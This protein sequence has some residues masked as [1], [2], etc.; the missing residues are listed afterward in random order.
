MTGDW[1]YLPPQYRVTIPV[2]QYAATLATWL[3]GGEGFWLGVMV[4]ICAMQTCY[5]LD[6]PLKRA[7]STF[8]AW[9]T[10]P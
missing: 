3:L 5:M 9:A 4:G 6:Q 1:V 8:W 10:R 7:F 2:G